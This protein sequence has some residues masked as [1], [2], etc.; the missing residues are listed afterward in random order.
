VDLGEQERDAPAVGRED[1]AVLVREAFE[2]ALAEETSQVIAHLPCGVR[3]G[4]QRRDQGTQL[5]VGQAVGGPQ[6]MTE[7]SEYCGDAWLSEF[8]R[9]GGLP[10]GRTGGLDEISQ[11]R[12]C[13]AAVVREP[14]GLE[15]AAIDVVAEGA[16]V[17]EVGDPTLEV[18]VVRVVEGRFGAERPLFFEVLLKVTFWDG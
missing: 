5:G 12:W 11:L 18:E 13:Q 17:L 4:E 10:G 14:F 16:E 8:Q 6:E 1:V 3:R 2:H 9:G 7:G 15:D